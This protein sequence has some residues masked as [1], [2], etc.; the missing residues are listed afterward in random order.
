MIQAE[1]Y[2]DEKSEK[3][4]TAHIYDRVTRTIWFYIYDWNHGNPDHK[5]SFCRKITQDGFPNIWMNCAFK[6]DLL[7]SLYIVYL[8]DS[9]M[10][11]NVIIYRM[12]VPYFHVNP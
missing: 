2:D 11:Q 7:L 5:N 6:T 12:F 3:L 4:V 9:S 1:G 8:K 10:L